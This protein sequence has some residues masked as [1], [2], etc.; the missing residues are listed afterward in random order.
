MERLQFD[1]DVF[2]TVYNQNPQDVQNFLTNQRHRRF[3]SFNKLINSLAGPDASFL[4]A[5]ATT[6]SNKL[7]DG[8]QRIDLLNAQLDSLRTRL[9]T[10]FQN[11]ELAIAKIQSN[12]S[13]ISSIQPFLFLNSV[14]RRLKQQ[15]EVMPRWESDRII[16][17]QY[18]LAVI[19][20]YE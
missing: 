6:L 19:R 3:R 1:Q 11:S 2:Q 13:A 7:T 15:C 20:I 16:P 4:V 12:L 10:Q 8:Q 14:V 17:F 18:V 5:R 9:T